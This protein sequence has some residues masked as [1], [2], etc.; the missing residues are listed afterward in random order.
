MYVFVFIA[1]HAN[2]DVWR[3]YMYVLHVRADMQGG[4]YRDLANMSTNA[5]FTPVALP[6]II[7]DGQELQAFFYFAGTR[8]SNLEGRK[9]STDGR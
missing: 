4:W 7:I 8:P 6:L 2:A 9:Y 5:R 1:E 3:S